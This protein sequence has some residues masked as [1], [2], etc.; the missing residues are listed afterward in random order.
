MAKQDLDQLLAQAEETLASGG[1][2]SKIDNDQNGKVKE[3]VNKKQS[4]DDKIKK[5][6]MQANR[7]A[8]ATEGGEV[9]AD[10]EKATKKKNK[11]G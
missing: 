5:S 8:E 11:K 4:I 1:D 7:A 9:V 2:L 6:R 10:G 3:P